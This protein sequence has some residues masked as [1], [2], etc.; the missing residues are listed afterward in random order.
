MKKYKHLRE[1]WNPQN[2]PFQVNLNVGPIWESWFSPGATLLPRDMASQTGSHIGFLASSRDFGPFPADSW[3]PTS[4]FWR[5]SEFSQM[6]IFLHIFSTCLHM[7][8]CIW[9]FCV[10]LYIFLDF[11]HAKFI[12]DKRGGAGGAPHPLP[13]QFHIKRITRICIKHIKNIY[14]YMKVHFHNTPASYH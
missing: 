10:F 9:I 4:G 11:L 7:F 1:F 14:K 13:Y 12:V 3:S 6:F 5:V 8:M 2:R